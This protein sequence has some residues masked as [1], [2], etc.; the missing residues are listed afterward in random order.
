MASKL[1][2]TEYS[3]LGQTVRGAAQVAKEPVI[4][5]QVV[6]YSGGVAASSAF[7]A[8]TTYV[9][10][11]TDSVCSIAFGTAPTA[12]TSNRRLPADTTEYFAVP[13]GSSY[14]V[15]AIANT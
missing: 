1:Y 13:V 3:D 14:K 15:S 9:R 12:T 10:V 7:N 5:E 2:V 11:H 6:D 8:A 4:A